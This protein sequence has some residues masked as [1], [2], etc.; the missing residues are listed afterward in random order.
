MFCSGEKY[1]EYLKKVHAIRKCGEPW[2]RSR[3]IRTIRVNVE[4]GRS[5]GGLSCLSLKQAANRLFGSLDE[6][7]R[8]AGVEPP[9]KRKD[10]RKKT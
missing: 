7:C 4:Y 3:I 9:K 2:T 6:A 5:H 1:W 8:A 10:R